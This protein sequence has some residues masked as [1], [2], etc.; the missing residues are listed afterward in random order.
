MDL[1]IRRADLDS[2]KLALGRAGFVYRHSASIDLFL[3]GPNAK[4]RDAVHII[5]AGET[6][7]VDEPLPNPDVSESESA[8]P[9]RIVSLCAWYKSS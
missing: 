5:F 9:F 6:V 2:V 4:A 7:R 8:G 3:D 1:L